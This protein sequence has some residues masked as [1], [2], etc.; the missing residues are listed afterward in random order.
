MRA[1]GLLME[2]VKTTR[3]QTILV[4]RH[5]HHVG[6]GYLG[7]FLKRRG[8]KQHLVALDRGEALP[9]SPEEFGAVVVLGGEMNVH[10]EKKHPFLK[11]ENT[12]IQQ[13]I[14]RGVPYLGLCLGGQLLAKA[15]GGEVTKNPVKEIGPYEIALT[16]SG[17]SDP[18]FAEFPPRFPFCQWHGDTFSTLPPD[19]VLLASNAMC[20]HQAFRLGAH[21]YGLQ[22]HPETTELVLANWCRDFGSDLASSQEGIEVRQKYA[23]CAAE[24]VKLSDRLFK[25]FFLAAKVLVA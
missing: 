15:M 19:A 25:N 7:D 16:E 18:L 6:P 22:F 4:L 10:D 5:S 14:Q 8:L 21:A 13:T 11:P 9:A 3:S 23:Q 17:S 24:C 1:D 12:F 20:K 2:D